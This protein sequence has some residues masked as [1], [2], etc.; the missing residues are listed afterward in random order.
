MKT[1]KFVSPLL[2]FLIISG[3]LFVSCQPK[4]YSAEYKPVTDAFMEAWNT[5]DVDGL[6]AILDPNFVRHDIPTAPGGDQDIDSLKAGIAQTRIQ[7]PNFNVALVDEIYSENKAAIHWLVTADAPGGGR[8]EVYGSSINR[9]VNGKLAEEWVY[10]DNQAV[11]VSMGATVIPPRPPIED[12][13]VS[14]EPGHY[15]VEFENELVRIIR[16][17]YAAGEE[18]QMHSHPP[19]VS[20]ALT[21]T[22]GS[23]TYPDGNSED[24]SF[25]GGQAVFAPAGTHKPSLAT[26]SE[27]IQIELKR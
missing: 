4:D 12:D 15:T 2:T 17:K 16:W 27:G 18:G 9:F 23:F 25:K 1:K 8:L 26:A 6:D 13:P 14:L 7:F 24:V 20:I 22:K 3:L 5:G 10:Y 21:D 11:S 19:S